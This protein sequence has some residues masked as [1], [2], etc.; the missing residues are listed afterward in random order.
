MTCSQASL[1]GQAYCQRSESSNFPPH[2]LAGTHPSSPSRHCRPNS[3]WP[4]WLLFLRTQPL[5]VSCLFSPIF[6]QPAAFQRRE[7]PSGCHWVGTSPRGAYPPAT[8]LDT[9]PHSLTSDKVN[10]ENTQHR[11]KALGGGRLLSSQDFTPH[12]SACRGCS[13]NAPPLTCP[14]IPKAGSH[15]NAA[16]NVIYNIVC[17]CV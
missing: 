1:W 4:V 9:Q 7:S 11:S 12:K 2:P 13:I 8:E 15:D 14:E 10:E 16:A 5:A 17:V 3:K 6:L